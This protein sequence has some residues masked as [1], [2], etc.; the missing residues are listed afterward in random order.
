[1]SFIFIRERQRDTKR[2]ES[3]KQY[4]IINYLLSTFTLFVLLLLI[5]NDM[6]DTD[7]WQQASWTEKV[8]VNVRVSYTKIFDIDTINQRFQA[9]AIIESSWHDPNIRSIDELI[10]ASKI[11]KPDVYVDNAINDSKDEVTY[12]IVNDYENDQLLICETRKVKGLFWECLELE[13]FPLDVQDLSLTVTSKKPTSMVDLIPAQPEKFQYKIKINNTLDKSMWKMHDWV[14]TKKRRL[15]REF[16]SSVTDAEKRK[17]K[18]FPAIKLTA[19][20][21]RLPGFFYYNAILP[22]LLVTLAS[23]GPFVIDFK[24]PQSRLP[25]T[26]TMLLTSV[27]IRWIVGRLLPTVSYLTSLDKYSLGSIVIIVAQLIYHATMGAINQALPEKV[28]YRL[29]KIVF[30]FILSLIIIKQIMFIVWVR[31]VNIY[32]HGVET[33]KIQHEIPDDDEFDKDSCDNFEI[34]IKDT[35]ESQNFLDYQNSIKSKSTSPPSDDKYEK[36]SGGI[37]GHL[38]KSNV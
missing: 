30:A 6:D 36:V 21:F 1:M 31:R 13:M 25:S 24:L 8:T 38:Y 33:N 5:I 34:E 20:V 11:W 9:E 37:N 10:D 15:I 3:Y 26:A 16:S 19:Q 2:K 12:R 35:K 7:K 28:A 4:I 29:D 18:R 22:I 14:F 32:R 27:S 17:I 23:L